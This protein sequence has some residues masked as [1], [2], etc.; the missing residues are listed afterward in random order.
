MGTENHKG[1]S[2]GLAPPPLW[3]F[4]S[5]VPVQR[6]QPT[7]PK[8]ESL[9]FQPQ[10][11]RQQAVDG[12]C[13]AELPAVTFCAPAYSGHRP[14]CN[15]NRWEEIEEESGLKL[16]HKCGGLFWTTK[17]TGNARIVCVY[18]LHSRVWF[19]GG[20]PISGGA[21]PYFS[22]LTPNGAPRPPPG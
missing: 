4:A 21:T 3:G 16:V 13:G 14:N 20:A 1:R 10:N 11:V 8:S 19:R 15:W 9:L 6:F 5:D 18:L 2:W 12:L 7:L 17:E 22:P